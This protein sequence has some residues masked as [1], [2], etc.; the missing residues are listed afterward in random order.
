VV[1]TFVGSSAS[2]GAESNYLRLKLFKTK[3]TILKKDKIRKK[4]SNIFFVGVIV[5]GAPCSTI[6]D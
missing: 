2:V 3:L 6:F 5:L 4:L 1:I